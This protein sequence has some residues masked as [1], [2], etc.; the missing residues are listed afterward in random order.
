MSK[1]LLFETQP[2]FSAHCFVNRAHFGSSR[3]HKKVGYHNMMTVEDCEV[4]A[5]ADPASMPR[6][7]AS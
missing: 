1:V 7:N 3:G 6:R 2:V 5:A 4:V